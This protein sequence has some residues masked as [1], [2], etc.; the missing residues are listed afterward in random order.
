MSVVVIGDRKVGKTSMVVNL[1]DPGT[2]HVRVVSNLSKYYD[3]ETKEIAGT[4]SKQEEPLAINVRLPSG[5]KQI[6][7]R[8]VDTPG[9]AWD[10]PAW[11][12]TNASAWKDIEQ[13]VSQSQGI[14]LLLP[15]H[16]TMVQ[17]EHLDEN[18]DL[19]SLPLSEAWTRNLEEWLMFFEKSCHHVQHILVAIHKADLF[20]DVHAEAQKWHYHPTRGPLWFDYNTYI[21]KT[22]FSS[23]KVSSL[24][25]A[26]SAQ[27]SGTNLRFFVTTIKDSSLLELPWVYLGAFLASS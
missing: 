21:R 24:I 25:R 3:P 5:E 16:R 15:P 23:S 22:Y 9:E 17:P 10:D 11:R 13:E 6:Q 27:K 2:E 12:K 4:R 1:H 20:C 8:W 7:V 14:L 19:D 26:Y 18:T